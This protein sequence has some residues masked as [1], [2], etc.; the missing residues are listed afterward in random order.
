[1]NLERFPNANYIVTD[2][3]GYKRGEDSRPSG[4]VQVET[5][6][7]RALV[8]I[9]PTSRCIVSD[10]CGV[11]VCDCQNSKGRTSAIWLRTNADQS[12]GERSETRSP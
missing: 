4:L 12:C 2:P 8:G 6:E 9:Q 10:Q 11:L 3:L 7:N 1:M 5:I